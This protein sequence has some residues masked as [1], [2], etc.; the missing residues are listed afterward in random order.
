M[1]PPSCLQYQFTPGQTYAL[2]PQLANTKPLL[3]SV[4]GN[5]VS[6][7]L[8]LLTPWMGAAVAGQAGLGAALWAPRRHTATPAPPASV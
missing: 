7:A 4:G 8:R 3:L 5:N 2:Y 1:R 6:A